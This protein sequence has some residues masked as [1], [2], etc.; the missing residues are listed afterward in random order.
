MG[1]QVLQVLALLN[2]FKHL[3]KVINELVVGEGSLY[4][5]L[6]DFLFIFALVAFSLLLEIP[7]LDQ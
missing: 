2:G 6:G 1:F 5:L 4:L 3:D 7:V